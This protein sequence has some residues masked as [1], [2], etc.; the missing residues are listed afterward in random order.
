MLWI[1]R[2]FLK[3]KITRNDIH[4]QKTR[5]PTRWDQK[6]SPVQID[7]RHQR[8]T[9]VNRKKNMCL[10]PALGLKT[11]RSTRQC[12][13]HLQYTFSTS[14]LLYPPHLHNAQRQVVT[15]THI[16]PYSIDMSR[17]TRLAAFV[18]DDGYLQHIAVSDAREAIWSKIHV[19]QMISTLSFFNT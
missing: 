16:R 7:S 4:V 18:F 8:K 1:A 12:S 19:P 6:D 17:T 9:D 11:S 10:H 5:R 13:S 2:I 15:G 3:I 14:A